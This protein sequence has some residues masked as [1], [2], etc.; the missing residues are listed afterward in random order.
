MIIG[1]AGTIGSGKG[2]VVEYLKSKGFV[3]YSSSGLLAELIEREGNP[4]TREFLAKMATRL[5][6]EYAG[7]VVEKSYRERYALEQPQN[8]V[9]E[10]IHRQTEAN[11]LKSASGFVV[12]VD[13]DIEVR[14]GRITQRQEGTKD[15]VTLEQF[16]E[17]A[18]VEDEGGGDAS[19]DNNIRAVIES[20]DFVLHNDG[21][22]EEL[23][24]K[25]DSM[26]TVFS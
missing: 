9:F 17:D 23:I 22:I 18:R 12:G 8:A 25:I 11:F 16:K 14:F 10:A 19:R 3:Q 5:Q 6:Q 13:A 20:S 4:K 15:Q 24:E 7:G 2:T 26:L 1:L 21:T